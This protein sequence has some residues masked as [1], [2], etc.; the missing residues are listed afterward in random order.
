MSR[1]RRLAKARILAA[2]PAP[3]P[4]PY[5]DALRNVLHAGERKGD[6]TGTGTISTTGVLIRFASIAEAYPLITTKKTYF[7]GIAVEALWLLSGDTNIQTLVQHG[8]HIWSDWPFKQW[9]E[10]EGLPIPE[11]ESEDW[12]RQIGEFE[13]RIK[14]DDQFA[15]EH[16]DLGPVYGKQWRAWNAP[17]HPSGTIDQFA[18]AIELIKNNPDSR[19]IIVNAWNPEFTDQVALPPCHMSFQFTVTNGK[20]SIAITQRSADMLLG[21]PFN[22]ASYA[23]ILMI[24]ARI[25]GLETG[26][27]SWFGV[28]AHI[29]SNHVAQVEEQLSREP[30]PYPTLRILDRGQETIDDFELGDFFLEGYD[31]HPAIRAKVAV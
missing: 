13:D 21:V 28:D 7:K 6:R 10:A 29:Y 11:Q 31:P 4:T 27:L 12:Q 14:T 30:R 15:R 2:R 24:A 18:N 26:S 19:R 23:M 17:S 20:L 25:T 1:T 3:I 16:G 9:L 8:V 5:E 22:I